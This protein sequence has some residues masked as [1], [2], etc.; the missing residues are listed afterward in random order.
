M[1]NAIEE[2]IKSKRIA[3]VGLSRSGKK[4]GNSA[5]AELLKRG[6]QVFAVH[7]D[8][9]EIGGTP[10]YPNLGALRG[11]VDAVLVCIAPGGVPSILR[12]AAL[13]GIRNV[14]L[15]QGAESSE[16]IALGNEL[17]FSL[18]VRKCIL[19][20]APPVEGFHAWHRA[21]Y[22]IFSKL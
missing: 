6:Y 8:A 21:V 22:R 15:Q 16:A 11:K 19:M 10:C 3:V 13:N 14:W 4:F 2:F 1:K 20:Y 12:E 9:A 7:P 17:D 18:V 5:F